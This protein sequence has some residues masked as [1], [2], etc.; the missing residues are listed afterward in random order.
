MAADTHGAKHLTMV[1][2]ET[3]C[4]HAPGVAGAT[5][6]VCELDA[7]VLLSQA[8]ALTSTPSGALRRNWRRVFMADYV[9]MSRH[10]ESVP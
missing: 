10:R 7:G 9:L 2:Y 6:G 4:L 3:L 1:G 5:G 8:T